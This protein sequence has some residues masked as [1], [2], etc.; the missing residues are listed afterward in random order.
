[1]AFWGV[2]DNG[3]SRSAWTG[4]SWNRE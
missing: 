2:L 1:M 3:Q 4:G